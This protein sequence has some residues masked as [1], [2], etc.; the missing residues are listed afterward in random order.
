LSFE[1]GTPERRASG[2]RPEPSA[3]RL[4]WGPGPSLGT[5]LVLHG[6]LIAAAAAWGAFPLRF[7]KDAELALSFRDPLPVLA[8]RPNELEPPNELPADEPFEAAPGDLVS[9]PEELLPPVPD[10]PT[11]EPSLAPEV[12]PPFTTPTTAVVAD[13]A[14][15]VEEPGAQAAEPAALTEGPSLIE[16]PEPAYPRASVLRGEEGRVLCR[17]SLSDAGVVLSVAIVESSGHARLDAAA[18]SALEQWRFRPALEAGVA[19][20]SEYAHAVVFRLTDA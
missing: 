20:P 11:P 14:P 12:A 2:A 4:T 10:P 6:A 19:V 8:L 17:L 1:P 13:A 7:G 9:A 5:S 3:D 16:G 18:V 15:P